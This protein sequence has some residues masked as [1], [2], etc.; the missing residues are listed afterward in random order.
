MRV[1]TYLTIV[2]EKGA[3]PKEKE[4]TKPR[5]EHSVAIK[6]GKFGENHNLFFNGFMETTL[7][8]DRVGTN[9]KTIHSHDCFLIL[10][11]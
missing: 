10:I 5:R 1:V 9:N 2:T 8:C 11:P 6:W 3:L 7:P 4:E